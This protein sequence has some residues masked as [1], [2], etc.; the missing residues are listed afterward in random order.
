MIVN[1][2]QVSGVKCFR[3]LPLFFENQNYRIQVKPTGFNKA[4]KW[5]QL[6]K[7]YDD[8]DNNNL[9]FCLFCTLISLGDEIKE[10]RIDIGTRNLE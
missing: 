1:E 9:R 7:N 5:G 2:V 3:F 10:K 4:D 8:G 6:R